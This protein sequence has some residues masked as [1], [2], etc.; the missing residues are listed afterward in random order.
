M[1]QNDAKSA[2][3][4]MTTPVAENESVKNLF[5]EGYV[6]IHKTYTYGDQW[7]SVSLTNVKGDTQ[8]ISI[9]KF[10][11][12]CKQVVEDKK[13]V[14]ILQAPYRGFYQG[15]ESNKPDIRIM[16]NVHFEEGFVLLEVL[17]SKDGSVAITSAS[18]VHKRSYYKIKQAVLLAYYEMFINE[19]AANERL[20][21]LA[22]E[23]SVN[24]SECIA[25]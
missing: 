16:G 14:Q 2:N 10:Q 3:A 24:L 13:F 17:Q 21:K 8:F 9:E 6:T 12:M 15:K 23:R 20:S 4:A 5:V 1:A 18:D 19:I 11:F 25:L 22:L 7:N